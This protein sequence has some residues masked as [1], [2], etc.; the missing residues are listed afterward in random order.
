MTQAKINVKD[1]RRIIKEELTAVRGIGEA[2][3]QKIIDGRLHN[4]R[5][6]LVR[7]KIAHLV[8]AKQAPKK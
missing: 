3:S 7:R 6:D 5:T 8:I 2:Y 1:L 4:A